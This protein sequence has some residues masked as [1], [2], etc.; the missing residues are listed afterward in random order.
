MAKDPLQKHIFIYFGDQAFTLSQL[1]PAADMRFDDAFQ[2]MIDNSMFKGVEPKTPWY[3]VIK[4][5]GMRLE[6]NP[7]EDQTLL[8]SLHKTWQDAEH[9]C[10]LL[11]LE[12]KLTP[13]DV[14]EMLKLKRNYDA[15]KKLST[16]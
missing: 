3:E 9:A 6:G 10:M 4:S 1:G 2:Y 8:F 16:L 7:T 13:D 5:S 11:D 12:G 15:A 14:E